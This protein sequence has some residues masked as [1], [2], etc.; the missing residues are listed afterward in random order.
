MTTLD[1]WL[2]FGV[3]AAVAALILLG[4]AF[5]G[6]G[7]FGELPDPVPDEFLPE[8]PQRALG[9]SDLAS[10]MFAT[11][12]RGYSPSQVDRLL[13]RAAEQ[14]A[15]ETAPAPGGAVGLPPRPP[16]LAVADTGAAWAAPDPASGQSE[17]GR[18]PAQA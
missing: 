16:A 9:P 7:R 12:A 10:A 18:P 3:F 8:L 17:D 6:A 15:R 14:W 2:V 13:A 11:V 4:A 5:A 1:Q